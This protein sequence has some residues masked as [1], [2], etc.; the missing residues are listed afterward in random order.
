MSKYP[1]DEWIEKFK[2]GSTYQEISEEYSVSIYAV[3]YHLNKR[4]HFLAKLA[5]LKEPLSE[6]DKAWIAAVIDCEGIITIHNP[7]HKNGSRQLQHYCRVQMVDN[8]V[9]KKLYELCG[10][11]Y[12]DHIESYK[13]NQ[14]AVSYWHITPRIMRWLFPQLLPYILIKKRR[15]EITLEILSKRYRGSSKTELPDEKLFELY[16]EM[17]TL[18]RRGKPGVITSNWTFDKSTLVSSADYLVLRK[19]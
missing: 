8:E 4:G 5:A 1:I 10:G 6:P 19:L 16:Q 12:I 17:R 13:P 18:N 3:R 7:L 14:R 15:M 2:T 11:S 9:T